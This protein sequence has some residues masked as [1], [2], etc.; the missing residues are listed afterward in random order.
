[1]G[2]EKV[3]AALKAHAEWFVRLRIAVEQGSSAFEPGMVATDNH[4]ELGKWLYGDFPQEWKGLPLFKD[5]KETHGQFHVEAARILRLAI[6]G[7]KEEALAALGVGTV[8]RKIS[9]NL[10]GK[11]Y[12]LKA[13]YAG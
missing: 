11:L 9:T 5:I 2:A 8:I 6:G 10:V 4:C 12:K 13:M 3:D 7:K 1:M